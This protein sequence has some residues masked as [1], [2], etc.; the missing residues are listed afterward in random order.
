MTFVQPAR[1][2]MALVA[3][4]ALPAM[5]QNLA[6]VNGKPIPSSRADTMIKQL[7]AQGQPDSPELRAMVREELIN[8]EILMQEA[9]RRGVTKNPDVQNQAEIA[10]Q[11]IAIRALVQDYL[12]KNPVSDAEIK[13]E[14][15]KFKAQS[16]DKE[17]HARHI[18]VETEEEA[19]G[20]INKLKGG[21][22]FE[23]LA[24]QS[25]DPG[26]AAAGGDLDWAPPGAFVKPFSDAMVS[27]QKG[28]FTQA[29]VQ[30]Q[31]GYHVIKLEDVRDAQLPSLEEVKPHIAESLQQQK[32][33]GFQEEL[34]K[35]AKI[36]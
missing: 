11:S 1:L 23:E 9:N 13:A 28:Q 3:A 10:R 26:S 32:L 14:Y 33:Q 15:D 25:K 16:G 5:A 18:L 30:T 19:K 34:R 2:L 27:L 4:I 7:Q 35:K 8:R 36:Q 29:P 20:I 22:K 24:K 31:Y 21:A 17:Y 6:V 12:E